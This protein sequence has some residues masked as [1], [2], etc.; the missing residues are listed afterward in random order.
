MIDETHASAD[1]E[2][3][4]YIDGALAPAER[5]ALEE[6]LASDAGLKARLAEL[7]AGNRRFADVYEVL[8]RNAPRARLTAALDGARMKFEAARVVER[9]LSARRWLRAAAAALVIFTA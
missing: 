3:V 2:L 7:A 1:P 6:R 5:E 8:L 4:A 9:R